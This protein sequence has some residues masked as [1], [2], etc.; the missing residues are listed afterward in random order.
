M[1]HYMIFSPL[2]Q[3]AVEL[4]ASCCVRRVVCAVRRAPSAVRSVT[5][6]PLDRFISDMAQ[7]SISPIRPDIFF[8]FLVQ[9]LIMDQK[10]TKNCQK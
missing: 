10:M 7:I 6:K 2:A 9:D 8:G 3:R 5:Q 4:M 1:I